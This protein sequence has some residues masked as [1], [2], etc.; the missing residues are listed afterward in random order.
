M[1]ESEVNSLAPII[2]KLDKKVDSLGKKVE[3]IDVKKGPLGDFVSGIEKAN[4]KLV[5]SFKAPLQGLADG[6]DSLKD[7]IASPF[8]KVGKFFTSPLK[9]FKFLTN[10]FK[11]KKKGE[12]VSML[13]KPL[14]A[15]KKGIDKLVKSAGEA[16]P[17]VAKSTDSIDKNT[18][19]LRQDNKSVIES[20]ES[21]ASKTSESLKVSSSVLTDAIN[22]SSEKSNESLSSIDKSIEKSNDNITTDRL[23]Q[24]EQRKEDIAREERLI[25]ATEE[26]ADKELKVPEEKPKGFISK[27]F[28]DFKAFIA[29]GLLGVGKTIV[30]KL[31]GLTKK[32]AGPLVGKLKETKLGRNFQAFRLR[33]DRR[34][35]EGKGA[36]SSLLSKS[37]GALDKAGAGAGKG[38]SKAGGGAG[39]GLS[40]MGKG[41]GKG[42]SG[43][44][45]GLAEGVKKLSNPKLLIG[46]G[47]LIAL[48]GALLITAKALKQFVGIDFKQVLFGVGTLALLGAGAAALGS[49]GPSILVG[50]LAIAALGASLIPAAVAFKQFSD[51]SWKDVFIGIGAISALGVVAGIMGSFIP[52]MLAG[53][54]AIAALGA[55]MIPAAAAFNIFGS[56]ME[57]IGPALSGVVDSVGDFIT[58]VVDGLVRLGDA[59]PK[60]AVAAG[61]IGLISAALVA[62]GAS[63]ALGGLLSFFGGN[64][65]KK[66]L[67]IADKSAQLKEAGDG[68]TQISEGTKNLDTDKVLTIADAFEVLGAS[69]WKLKKGIPKKFLKSLSKLNEIKLDDIAINF[70][71][72]G[73]GI[74][75][76]TGDIDTEKVE[77]TMST[78][79]AVASETALESKKKIVDASNSTVLAAADT[80]TSSASLDSN[81]TVEKKEKTEEEKLVDKKVELTKAELKLAEFKEKELDYKM[82]EYDSG[83]GFSTHQDRKYTSAEDQSTYESLKQ[84]KVVAHNDYY[85]GK[86]NLFA[87]EKRRGTEDLFKRSDFVEEKGLS[88]RAIFDDSLIDEYFAS[89]AEEVISSE[90][91]SSNTTTDSKVDAESVTNALDSKA[92]V[93]KAEEVISSENESS[94]T[95]TDSKVD[96]ESVTNAL[97]SKALVTKAEEVISSENESS[98]TESVDKG[99]TQEALKVKE[100][101]TIMKLLANKAM[102][103]PLFKLASSGFKSFKE[104]A[105][106]NPLTDLASSVK[107]KS[108]NIA[109]SGVESFKEKATENPL[110]DLA[111]SVKEKST[112]IA[113]SGVESFKEKFKEFGLAKG[114][115]GNSLGKGPLSVFK[116]IAAAS[117]IGSMISN[118]VNSNPMENITKALAESGGNPILALGKT[119]FGKN[120]KSEKIESL[121]NNQSLVSEG[122]LKADDPMGGFN[123]R[124]KL[125]ENNAISNINRESRAEST[126][127][128]MIMAGGNTSQVNN[129]TTINNNDKHIDRTMDYLLPAGI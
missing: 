77:S 25:A 71:Y 85:Q 66:F 115:D 26:A 56:A 76:L 18:N 90:N 16:I 63:S 103:N 54:L 52:V 10:I 49:V 81:A 21:T 102:E 89:K 31:G 5:D 62:F 60:L 68:I 75:A 59:G 9:S 22:N 78:V 45:G 120:D 13:L 38:M 125:S 74:K 24:R 119:I 117:P 8:K 121:V 12:E 101:P 61:G 92:L 100:Q 67:E 14:D 47:V 35:R 124:S 91:E 65:I 64:P 58:N 106:K 97:D 94:N 86:K 108:T 42:M 41:A 11:K 109:S 4:E 20:V 95:T 72:I 30:G 112:N 33:K 93:T 37:G 57:K 29:V 2:E 128:A 87:S 104:K 84:N 98:N 55:A 126:Q 3:D 118:V 96:A 83:D 79:S 32:I 82:A 6:I 34:G 17:A 19:S 23:Q 39:A 110:T 44:L 69:L 111:S 88:E 114:L 105:A 15:I 40:K 51:I 107:E 123:M 53:S 1:P 73:D 116:N 70:K 43:F 48:G 46:A 7:S 27:F 80:V 127:S 129:N 99:I 50:A 113:S 36:K 122:K 28:E